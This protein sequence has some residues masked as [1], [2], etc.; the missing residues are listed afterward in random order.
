MMRAREQ[1]LTRRDI[2]TTALNTSNELPTAPTREKKAMKNLRELQ[3]RSGKAAAA[4]N[5]IVSWVSAVALTAALL[6]MRLKNLVC[7]CLPCTWITAG[8]L[9][10][11]YEM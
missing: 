5:T 8:I 9:T 11:L 10:H 1:L 6:P 2:V 7:V 3:I 4:K